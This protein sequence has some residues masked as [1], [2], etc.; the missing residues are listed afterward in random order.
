MNTGTARFEPSPKS[1][2]RNLT[3]RGQ[4]KIGR[5]G[6]FMP[7]FLITASGKPVLYRKTAGLLP[8]KINHF[9][10]SPNS[11]FVGIYDPAPSPAPR[12]RFSPE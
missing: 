2:T 12:V 9:Y 7:V 4:L 3:F 6:F 1:Q 8:E 10:K 11:G 5:A